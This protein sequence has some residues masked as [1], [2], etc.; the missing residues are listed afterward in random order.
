MANRYGVNYDSDRSIPCLRSPPPDRRKD[1]KRQAEEDPLLDEQATKGFKVK[2]IKGVTYYAPN[3]IQDIETSVDA[4]F[5]EDSPPD[6]PKIQTPAL[7]N[8]VSEKPCKKLP[9]EDLTSHPFIARK[10]FELAMKLERVRSLILDDQTY[11]R[12]KYPS[13]THVNRDFVYEF[14]PKVIES[15]QDFPDVLENYS[16]QAIYKYVPH[17]DRQMAVFIHRLANDTKPDEL[18]VIIPDVDLWAETYKFTVATGDNVNKRP[19]RERASR[20]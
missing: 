2:G 6:S 13:F 17:V 8:F 14:F 9:L 19:R 20:R 3:S 5:S 1:R 15:I 16:P 11:I 7:K 10:N 12:L 4:A 18:P